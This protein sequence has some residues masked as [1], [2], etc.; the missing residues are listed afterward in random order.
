M[1]VEPT[2]QAWEDHWANLYTALFIEYSDIFDET[3]DETFCYFESTKC[4]LQII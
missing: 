1:G 3:F 2:S 4:A